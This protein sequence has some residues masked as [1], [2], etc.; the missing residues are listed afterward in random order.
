MENERDRKLVERYDAHATAYQELWAPTLRLASVHLLREL[1]GKPV[2][3]AIDVGTGVG[4]LW[5]DLRTALPD[6]FVLGLDRSPGMLQIAPPEM[7]RV[8]ADA[9]A[10]PLATASVDLVLLVFMLFHLSDPIDGLREARR[11]LRP[12]GFVGSVTWGSGLESPATQI[13][14]Q[15]L[16]EHGAA[17]TDPVTEARDEP[18]N[19]PEKIDALLRAAGFEAIRA[20]TDDL[21]TVITVLSTCSRLGKDADG[22]REGP[23][24]QPQCRCCLSRVCVT[25]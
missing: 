8:V 17:P 14:T 4:A 5:F 20:W 25:F 16:D 10:L 22:Q 6:A 3:R 2:R 1:A 13:W 15:C 7:A 18:L 21:I 12:G 23:I 9:R 11:V 19:T 24:R